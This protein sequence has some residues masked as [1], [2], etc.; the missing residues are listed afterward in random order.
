MHQGYAFAG[1]CFSK[2]GWAVRE[3]VQETADLVKFFRDEIAPTLGTHCQ[4]KTILIGQSMG[5]LIG[6]YS[7]LAS[8]AITEYPY[9][10]SVE[11]HQQIGYKAS[12]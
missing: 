7:A 8:T 6:V 9:L 12:L 1:S 2:V 5:A 11:K 10:C 4:Y 3:G